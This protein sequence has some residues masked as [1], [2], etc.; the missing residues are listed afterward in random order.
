[1]GLS[2]IR[3]KAPRFIPIVWE[4]PPPS[5]IKVNTDGS[6]SSSNRA[7][8]GAIF[9]SETS[10]FIGAFSC[11][12]TVNSAIEAEL[13]AVIEAIWVARLK[14]WDHLEHAHPL[15]HMSD[16]TG[17]LGHWVSTLFTATGLLFPPVCF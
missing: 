9:R 3:P 16:V 13:L 10:S 14:G 6:F 5:W 17:S 12:V 8:Y 15:G 7:G 11:K 2:T 1:L 4:S